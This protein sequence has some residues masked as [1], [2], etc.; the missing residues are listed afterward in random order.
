MKKSLFNGE[1]FD[2]D[3]FHAWKLYE[4]GN[5]GDLRFIE[6]RIKDK[7]FYKKGQK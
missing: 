7:L 6:T 2:P 5:E 3:M 4:R 1:R